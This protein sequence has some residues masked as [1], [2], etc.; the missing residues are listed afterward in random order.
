MLLVSWNK[1]DEF[2]LSKYVIIASDISNDPEWGEPAEM[3]MKLEPY[4]WDIA[5]VDINEFMNVFAAELSAK[6]LRNAINKTHEVLM[7]DKLCC[8]PEIIEKYAN[9]V[10][11]SLDS[12]S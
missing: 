5:V 11:N 8:R 3:L 4:G 9:E 7:N 10:S 2:N 12:W 1:M 6:E